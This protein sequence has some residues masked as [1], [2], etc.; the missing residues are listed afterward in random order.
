M[1]LAIA[2]SGGTAVQTETIS[3]TQISIFSPLVNSKCFPM[4]EKNRKI[5]NR[6]TGMPNT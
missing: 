1:Y 3:K 4:V 5:P 2:N 6:P